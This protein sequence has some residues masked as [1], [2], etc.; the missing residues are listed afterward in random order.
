MPRK[1]TRNSDEDLV[2]SVADVLQLLGLASEQL[3]GEDTTTARQSRNSKRVRSDEGEIKEFITQ[4]ALAGI[5]SGFRYWRHV[6][7]IHEAYYPAIKRGLTEMS[8]RSQK[9]GEAPR[10][11]MD[12]VRAYLHEMIELPSRESRLLR[13]QFEKLERKLWSPS[14]QEQE[15]PYWR[16]WRVK[17]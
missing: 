4:A 8:A 10:I 7:D 6:A 9:N 14:V 12:N 17:S 11:L 5:M 1:K 15:G 3:N 2:R 13:D 16:R